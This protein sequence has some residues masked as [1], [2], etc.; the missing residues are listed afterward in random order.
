M[1]YD[2]IVIGAGLSGLASASL[3]A[4]RG[5]KVCVIEHAF[6]PG[7]SCGIF[8][9]LGATFDQ[10]SAML[11]GFGEKG[12]NAHR[13]L[14][15]V[16]EEPIR[17][18]RHRSLYRVCYKG[19]MIEFHYDIDKYI[20]ALTAVFPKEKAHLKRFYR[21]MEKLYVH[22]IAG[23]PTFASPDQVEPKDGLKQVLKH[24]ISYIKFL[25][26]MNLSTKELLKR[27]FGDSDIL[28][29]F[30]KLTSTYCYTNVEETPAVLAAVMFVDNHK[31][32]SYYPAGSTL[33][34]PGILEKVIEENG[35]DM[36]YE[37]R[38]ERVI[39]KDN[40]V[41]GVALC[42]GETLTAS[43]VVY[44]GTV[45]NLY[46]RLLASAIVPEKK[47]AWASNIKPSYPSS[48]L[49]ALVR[50]DVIPQGTTPITL[51]TESDSEL[52]ENEV[53][54]YIFSLDD[55]TICPEAYHTVM[56]IGPTFRKWPV[57][58][59]GY[60]SS[61]E[62]IQMKQE[63]EERLMQVMERRFPGF[64]NG[65][66]YKEVST[67]LTIER[68]T[69]KNG[70]SVAG[71]M[72]S[73][74]QHMLR[75]LHIKTEYE[76]LYCCGESTV[77][78]TGTPAV[79]VS[80]ISAANAILKN[81]GL[82]PYVY[83]A[84]IENRVMEIEP[85]YTKAAEAQAC[86]L[87]GIVREKALRCEYCEK[88]GCM[89]ACSLDIRGINRRLAAKNYFGAVKLLK[90]VQYDTELLQKASRQ[91]VLNQNEVIV[92]IVAVIEGLEKIEI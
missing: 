68:Y 10:G 28:G 81:L 25:S 82:A 17:M 76:G 41:T 40:R 73:M 31:G 13:F 14:H 29:Y 46:G 89:Q 38:A 59:D 65:A 88:P 19:R 55:H 26:L 90:A 16:L 80:G 32:G 92:D 12:F 1:H 30:N 6:K 18:I 27:Y 2:A 36:L 53:T 79:T 63:E 67:P 7:G 23:T 9:R 21:D 24:P 60:Q 5:L 47:K 20:E 71:P 35:G 57:Y 52:D 34:V 43:H 83:S 58:T 48:I 42:T 72:Q 44:S 91:C 51:F 50:K 75:R 15:N 8:K 62:Y 64:I 45:W 54:A 11:Y 86:G 61:D 69:L 70:G 4:K 74:G 78:G 85:P 77:M 22:V 66:V 56:A 49:Y 39:I 37:R 3:M 33:L 87:K 84:A